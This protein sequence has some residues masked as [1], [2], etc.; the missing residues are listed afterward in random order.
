MN[1]SRCIL[2]HWVQIC[3]L[4]F[5]SCN[6]YGAMWCSISWGIHNEVVGWRHIGVLLFS[7]FSIPE[8]LLVVVRVLVMVLVTASIWLGLGFK[9][10]IQSPWF[11]MAGRYNKNCSSFTSVVICV[12]Q[13]FKEF[14]TLL[15]LIYL[16]HYSEKA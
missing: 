16:I 9:L 10:T 5:C 13:V 14:L 3:H 6:G 12:L 2:F 11:R 1:V 4:F 15:C 8:Q 7:G